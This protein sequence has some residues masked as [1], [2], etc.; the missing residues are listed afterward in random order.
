MHR[1]KVL[2]Q[3]CKLS[4][5]EYTTPV[6]VNPVQQAEYL[7]FAKSAARAAGAVIL[8]Y[9]RS[10]ADGL[11]LENKLQQ[12]FDPVTLADRQAEQVIRQHI[13]ER[14]PE[15][16]IYG[17]EFGL[18]S[19]DG[20]TWVI[21]PID[22]TRAFMSG[23]LHWGVLLA[24][25]DG[26]KPIVGVLYQPYTDELFFGDGSS[27][28]FQRGDQEMPLNT[29]A[30]TDLAQSILCTT[31][32]EW[33]DQDAVARYQNLASTVQLS[34]K[35]GDCYLFAL[36]AMGQMHIGLDGSLNPYDIQA[37]IPIIRGAGGIITTWDGGN[38]SMGGHVV[39]SANPELHQQVLEKLQP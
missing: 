5:F 35:G 21:D 22:G 29:G 36:V 27:A 34:C 39:A 24:L 2:K 18:Q 10:G 20:L 16:G 38:P 13:T 33:L 31:G 30:T 8:P 23:M 3:N 9:F 32:T 6:S 11:G 4:S 15:H 25:F 28:G 26:E 1:N 37:L 12:G 7:D 17:E 19:G 14:Y